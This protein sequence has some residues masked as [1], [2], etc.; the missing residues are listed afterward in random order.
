MQYIHLHDEVLINYIISLYV[1][2]TLCSFIILYVGGRNERRSEEASGRY[3]VRE[4]SHGGR[5]TE[6]S[7]RRKEKVR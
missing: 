5:E 4:T 3:D 2:H 6:E 1:T 7:S